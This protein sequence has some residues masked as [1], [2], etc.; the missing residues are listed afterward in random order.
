M[1]IEKL[2]MACCNVTLKTKINVYHNQIMMWS[3]EFPGLPEGIRSNHEVK[4]F[5]INVENDSIDIILA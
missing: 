2:M 1:T 3:T 5:N 4:M